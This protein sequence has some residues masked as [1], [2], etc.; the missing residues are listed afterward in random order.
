MHGYRNPEEIPPRT[1]AP[2]VTA[3]IVSGEK[4]MFSLVTLAPNAIVPT[5]THP[6][7]QMGMMV[8]GTMEFTIAGETRVLSGNAMYLVPGGVP[9]A[10]KAGPG[11]AVALDAFAPPREEY[12]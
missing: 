12:R 4:L 2:G 10:A 6:H 5:H 3:K 9:H 11:G 8:S 1:L 7:E